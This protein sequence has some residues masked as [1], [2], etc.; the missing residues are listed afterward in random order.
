MTRKCTRAIRSTSFSEF[1]YTSLHPASSTKDS[2]KLN[3]SWQADTAYRVLLNNSSTTASISSCPSKSK[4]PLSHSRS[5]SLR[6]SATSCLH[7]QPFLDFLPLLTMAM[8]T[9]GACGI[10]ITFGTYLAS[11]REK[12]GAS[13]FLMC[14]FA[15]FALEW[16]RRA[17]I[18]HGT[19]LG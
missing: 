16:R 1:V 3:S 9:N 19:D 5:H 12:Y 17:T 10:F 18:S 15:R 14:A 11:T 7:P 2:N 4:A 8:T 6:S 13:Q